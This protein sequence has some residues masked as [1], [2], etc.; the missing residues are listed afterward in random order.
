MSTPGA[1][2]DAFRLERFMLDFREEKVADVVTGAGDSETRIRELRGAM[3]PCRE[4][5]V[6]SGSF[7]TKF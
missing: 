5:V 2:A 3:R 7:G 6:S 4:A 1:P